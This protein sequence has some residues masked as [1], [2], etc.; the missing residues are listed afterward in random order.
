MTIFACPCDV[1]TTGACSLQAALA[2]CLVEEEKHAG[3]DVHTGGL[4]KKSD[5]GKAAIQPP[6]LTVL[7]TPVGEPEKLGECLFLQ[8]HRV[9]LNYTTLLESEGY[10]L[11]C[12]AR[13]YLM[14]RDLVTGC[15]VACLEYQ[16][17]GQPFSIKK[18]DGS[19]FTTVTLNYRIVEGL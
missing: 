4:A 10:S 17:R 6:Y 2:T 11:A 16:R 9:R 8:R 19:W 7:E 15:G 1:D 12:C 13:S 5:A 3:I 14:G 18:P